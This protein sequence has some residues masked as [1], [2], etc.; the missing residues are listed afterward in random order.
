MSKRLRGNITIEMSYVFPI[1]IIIILIMCNLA[2]FLS[3]IVSMRTYLQNYIFTEAKS[4]KTEDIMEND[5]KNKL[6]SYTYIT[7]ITN[8]NIDK[9]KEIMK[10]KVDYNLESKI[11]DINL[12][13]SIEAEGYIESNR[14]YIV[15]TKIL[16][17][18]I[19]D[20]GGVNIWKRFI[21]KM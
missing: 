12:S 7:K 2:L 20:M 21:K 11:M 1:I 8:V 4:N 14:E 18:L 15:R 3:D 16:V 5:L 17:D 10:V 9:E 13:D 6:K 19:N